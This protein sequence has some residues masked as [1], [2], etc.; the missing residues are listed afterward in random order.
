MS[1]RTSGTSK[2][3]VTFQINYFRDLKLLGGCIES[4]DPE[5]DE[6]GFTM[7]GG[8]EY[9]TIDEKGCLHTTWADTEDWIDREVHALQEV[10]ST[11][12]KFIRISVQAYEKR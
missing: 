9:F 4:E 7:I 3:L 1:M 5:E 6:V 10:T 12:D 11:G 8:D 2:F